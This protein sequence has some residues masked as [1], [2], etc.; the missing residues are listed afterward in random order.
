MVL[1]NVKCFPRALFDAFLNPCLILFSEQ[2]YETKLRLIT[3]I[4]SLYKQTPLYKQNYKPVKTIKQLQ[5]PTA[6]QV[7]IGGG[8]HIFAFTSKTLSETNTE[9]IINYSVDYISRGQW[10]ST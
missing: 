6:W 10:L 8:D 1:V 9:Q 2:T 3:E 5:L 7:M 4:I